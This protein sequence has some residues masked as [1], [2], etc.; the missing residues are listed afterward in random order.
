MPGSRSL[1]A[2][3]GEA[4]RRPRRLQSPQL[5]LGLIEAAEE[6]AGRN[7][8]HA[9]VRFRWAL[10]NP[11]PSEALHMGV[12]EIKGCL[13]GVMRESYYLG[14]IIRGPFFRKLPH[15][16]CKPLGHTGLPAL[17]AELAFVARKAADF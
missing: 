4:R 15:G 8:L 3:F 2:G 17:A 9:S 6:T 14:S 5:R 11:S 1:R 16:D 13:I 12:S 7:V 10:G